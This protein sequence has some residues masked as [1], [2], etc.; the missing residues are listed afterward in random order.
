MQDFIP[1]NF[2]ELKM[3]LFFFK[4]VQ[5]LRKT[6]NKWRSLAPL[7]AKPRHFRIV[8]RVRLLKLTSYRF[9]S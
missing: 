7:S 9:S 6:K 5:P 8:L 2:D 1:L 4:A 3:E